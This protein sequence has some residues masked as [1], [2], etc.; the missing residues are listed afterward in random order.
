MAI[1]DD[2]YYVAQNKLDQE[3]KEIFSAFDRRIYSGL[4]ALC[5]SQVKLFDA[6][7]NAHEKHTRCKTKRIDVHTWKDA[8][9][10]ELRIYSVASLK[11][12]PEQSEA[13]PELT[14]KVEKHLQQ[15]N[16]VFT[17]IHGHGG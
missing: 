17:K 11:F 13:S 7:G 4:K 12:F 5:E 3:L 6:I 16:Q 15:L 1:V 14:F 2:D 8:R 10:A 9:F